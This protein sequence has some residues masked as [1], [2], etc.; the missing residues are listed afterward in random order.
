MFTF[1]FNW[2]SYHSQ[3]T[4]LSLCWSLHIQ[5]KNKADLDDRV[6][7]LTKTTFHFSTVL[8]TIQEAFFQDLF[9]PKK[10]R[11]DNYTVSLCRIFF[12]T[13]F[14]FSLKHKFCQTHFT[15]VSFPFIKWTVN[16]DDIKHHA[17]DRENLKAKITHQTPM[18]ELNK[19]SFKCTCSQSVGQLY[20]A[21]YTF[22]IWLKSFLFCLFFPPSHRTTN[23]KFPGKTNGFACTTTIFS[24][25][26]N[27]QKS[28]TEY[29]NIHSRPYSMAIK[30]NQNNFIDFGN[31]LREALRWP[32]TI[33]QQFCG[34]F[35]LTQLSWALLESSW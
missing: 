21:W 17:P 9:L 3:D 12:P 26:L 8:F 22:Q 4:G 30:A 34:F 11:T 10:Y 14:E 16:T 1:V 28:S 2:K 33:N 13:Q 7:L 25:I 24:K 5:I 18:W 23:W 6:V 27:K 29:L 15:P 31:A 32:M 19:L 35:S 20:Q